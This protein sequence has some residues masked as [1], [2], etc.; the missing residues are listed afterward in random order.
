VLDVRTATEWRTESIPGSVNVPL[1][2]LRA[3]LAEVPAGPRLVVHCQSGYRSSIA[4]SLLAQLGRTGLVDL[5][6]G[7]A[8]WKVAT[9][10]EPAP[11]APAGR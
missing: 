2:E 1:H 3:R 10:P 5:V 4:V 8:A 11:V 9:E 6:G 7:I